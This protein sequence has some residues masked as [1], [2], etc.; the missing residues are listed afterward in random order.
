V[1]LNVEGGSFIGIIIHF[2]GHFGSSIDCFVGVL[3][4]LCLMKIKFVVLLKL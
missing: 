3:M 1:V 4:H 2:V